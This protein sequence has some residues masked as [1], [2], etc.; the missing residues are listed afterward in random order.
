V[1]GLQ[2]DRV[3]LRIGDRESFSSQSRTTKNG[4]ERSVPVLRFEGA[5]S[6]P[7]ISRDSFVVET[8]NKIEQMQATLRLLSRDVGELTRKVTD[9]QTAAEQDH[10]WHAYQEN[11]RRARSAKFEEV[12]R[13]CRDLKARLDRIEPRATGDYH[14][15]NSFEAVSRK[16]AELEHFRDEARRVERNVTRRAWLFSGAMVLASAIIVASNI[17]PA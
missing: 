7:L 11:D 3:A 17:L 9:M 16:L 12:L 6:V 2:T 14:A 10:R 15:Y 5:P 1:S 8:G 13:C 4:S